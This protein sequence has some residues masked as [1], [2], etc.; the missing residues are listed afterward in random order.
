MRDW[1]IAIAPMALAML[2]ASGATARPV[3][4]PARVS[5]PALR[6]SGTVTAGVDSFAVALFI[7]G[8]VA[9]VR[10]RRARDGEEQRF[11]VTEP[12]SALLILADQRLAFLWPAL[13]AWAGPS[14]EGL[15]ARALANIRRRWQDGWSAAPGSPTESSVRPRTRALLQYARALWSLG[16]RDEA[17]GLLRA[18]LAA[19][20]RS[21]DWD[22]AEYSMVTVVLANQ[23]YADDDAPAADAL[24]KETERALAGT[25]YAINATINRAIL[26]VEQGRYAEGLALV[27]DA[28]AAFQVVAGKT[29]VD[30]GEAIPGSLRQFAWIKSCALHGLGRASEAVV[31]MRPVMAEAEPRGGGFILNSNSSV[32]VRAFMCMHDAGAVADEMV[33]RIE[34]TS[35]SPNELV[36]LQPTFHR[37]RWNPA[38]LAAV[39]ADPRVQAALAG[40]MHVLAPELA[41]AVNG[42]G[43]SRQ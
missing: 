6:V 26:A 15:R 22:R 8:E 2:A 32:R 7:K 5:D 36:T 17:N 33:K 1:R 38:T 3:V 30:K 24:H 42:W 41:L 4:D 29:R 21:S 20:E 16:Q 9:E 12:A 31:W 19:N 39:R 13:T 27:D 10:V 18:R 14:L 11:P 25:G 37:A 35:L 23:L 28:F 40:R 34:D 43:A